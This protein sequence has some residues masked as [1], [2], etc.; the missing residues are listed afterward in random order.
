[1]AECKGLGELGEFLDSFVEL[2]RS[3][4]GRLRCRAIERI[5]DDLIATTVMYV[6]DSLLGGEDKCAKE[7]VTRVGIVLMKLSRMYREGGCGGG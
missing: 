6:G 5:V 1:M 4:D 7:V 2:A 3:L